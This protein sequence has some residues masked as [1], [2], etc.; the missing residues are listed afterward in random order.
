MT[1]GKIVTRVKG[2][3]LFITVL[4]TSIIT[5]FN[6]SSGGE[7]AGMRLFLDTEVETPPVLNNTLTI[8]KKRPGDTIQFQ[9]FAPTTAD[10]RTYGYEMELALSDDKAFFDHIGN[11][12]GKGFTGKSLRRTPGRP[13]IAALSL[14]IPTVPEN[15][16]L[17]QI[18]LQV[19]KPLEEETTLTVKT[20][21]MAGLSGELDYLDISE[22]AISFIGTFEPSDSNGDFDGDFDVDFVDFLA[23]VGVFGVS[24]SDTNFDARMDMDGDGIIN[25]VDFLAFVDAF[26]NNP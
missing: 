14:S 11:I 17:G 4:T 8:P 25:F 10:Q 20:I 26:S 7:F 15:G 18:N 9:L 5:P 13:R 2:V 24:V 23:F 12:S 1:I 22:A 6:E 16:Y 3:L 21:V 19:I